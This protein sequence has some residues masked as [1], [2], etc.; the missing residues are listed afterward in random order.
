MR[1]GRRLLGLALLAFAA[2]LV[3]V[4]AGGP[5]PAAAVAPWLALAALLALDLALSL[6]RPV[7][8]L[9]AAPAE[10]FAGES[11]I[12]ELIVDG[13]AP[14]RLAGRLDW[15]HGLDGP[16]DAA[17]APNAATGA[18]TGAVA[19]LAM[20]ARRRGTWRLDRLWLHWP[21]RLRLLEFTPSVALDLTVVVVPSLRPMLSGTI[22]VAV[23]SQL[24]GAKENIVKGEGSEF[25]QLRDFTA[26]M[27]SR[28][29]D[30]KRSARYR[31]LVAKEM[32]A[33][34]NHH[35]MLALDN[36]F[37]MREEIDGV[38]KIDHA[39]NAA[40]ATAW[41]AAIGGDLVGLF[42]FDSRPRHFLP[43]EPG[44]R[45]FAK[46]RSRTAA[47]DYETRET[48][49]TLAMTHL[50]G[51][52]Q[53][54]SLVVVFTDFVD[55]TTAELLV[56]NV[57]LLG[58]RHVV[59]FVALR[60]PALERLATSAPRSLDDVAVAVSAGE[61]RRERLIV[62]ERLARLGIVVLDVEPA[63]VTARLVSTYLDLKAREV[64]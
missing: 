48:N 10:L 44:R 7:G 52:L 60:D 38:A 21:S 42:A 27:D 17:F 26:G 53:R 13:A 45:A 51:R 12:V 23:R 37:L 3:A 56:E 28:A 41:A 1:P 49:H 61:M 46:L 25:H 43:P 20:R 18:A 22:D 9:V 24:F 39:V 19:R 29:I 62:M 5:T 2:S 35:V 30:W 15:P 33:E 11:G 54:R 64:I 58:R 36:G 40:L 59:V 34:R 57:R 32:R 8:V 50:L 14:A 31:R 63:A 6:R 47:L 55:T 16:P 4:A